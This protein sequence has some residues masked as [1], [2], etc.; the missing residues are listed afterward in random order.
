MVN[1]KNKKDFDEESE[2]AGQNLRVSDHLFSSTLR[3]MGSVKKGL[4]VGVTKCTILYSLVCFFVE[5]KN[6]GCRVE[7]VV[8]R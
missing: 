4:T 3:D 7:T 8:R 2:G 5:S 1:S 6:M